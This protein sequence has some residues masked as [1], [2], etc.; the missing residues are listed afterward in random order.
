MKLFDENIILTKPTMFFIGVTTHNSFINTVFNEWLNI[1]GK[2]AELIGVNLDLNCPN[3]DYV[4]IVSFIKNNPFVL[5]ALVTTHKV[6]L[7][8]STFHLFDFLPNT[9]K[10]FREIGC[11]YKSDNKLT[12]EVTD[13]ISVRLALTSFLSNNYFLHIKSEFCILGAGGAGI[14]LAYR[15]LTDKNHKPNK[16]I[17][18]D[19]SSERIES[20]SNIL[21]KYDSEKLLETIKV[22]NNNTD[23]IIEKLSSG[24]VIVNATGLGKDKKGTPFSEK[25]NLPS[26]CYFWDFNYRGNLTFLEIAKQQADRKNLI[27][28]DGWIYF[29]HGWT[30]VISKVFHIDNI[31]SYFIEFLKIADIKK[32]E[33]EKGST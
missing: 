32:T 5:G 23:E 4:K 2:D 26:R 12:A 16:L 30:Q 19:I 22:E 33:T 18:T 24:S 10:E 28:L 13:I 17:I 29:I 11:I 25:I 8:N 6:N 31:E 15:I 21:S 3:E 27:V 9:C 1:I 20:A 14:A 7:Y